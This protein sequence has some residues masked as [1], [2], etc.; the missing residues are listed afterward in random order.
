M[1]ADV[2]GDGV[3]LHLGLHGHHVG[4]EVA[5]IGVEVGDR[6]LVLRDALHQLLL[7]VDIAGTH[8]EDLL[9]LEGRVLGVA[10]EVD[11]LDV[12]LRSLVDLDV[13]I[14][15][16]TVVRLVDRVPQDLCVAVALGVIGLEDI[17][18]VLLV[19][20]FHELLRTED[21]E[22]TAPGALG[23]VEDLIRLLHSAP[24]GVVA[25]HLVADEVDGRDLRLRILIDVKDHHHIA[26]TG[27]VLED[28]GTH[29]D[30]AESL[31]VIESLDLN[32]GPVENIGRDEGPLGERL[33]ATVAEILLLALLH[34]IELKSGQPRAL[35]D[36]DREPDRVALHTVGID[37][38]I[39]EESIAEVVTH[40][41]AD[42]LTWHG[43]P[44]SQTKTGDIAHHHILVA[45]I[46]DHPQSGDHSRDGTSVGDIRQGRQAVR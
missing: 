33:E 12:V 46:A 28:G 27:V 39:G 20:L 40:R 41:L 37:A 29:L 45:L 15:L 17:L 7:I 3:P 38:D 6:I 1:D 19:L 24:Q 35:G 18:Q 30:V 11:R 2:E 31:S 22:D 26:G 16:L 13:D 9:E 8:T 23:E 5:V 14:D 42:L 21:L 25:E 34:P 43:D 10:D 36:M 4:K 44:L 32:L